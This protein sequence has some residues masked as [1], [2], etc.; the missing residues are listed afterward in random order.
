MSGRFTTA[1]Q[2]LIDN[3]LCGEF[4]LLLQCQRSA[5]R[6][7]ETGCHDGPEQMLHEEAAYIAAAP[8]FARLKDHLATHGRD[9]QMALSGLS[10]RPSACVAVRSLTDVQTA[11]PTVVTNRKPLPCNVFEGGNLNLDQNREL[12]NSPIQQCTWCLFCHC[13]RDWPGCR[14]HC[15]VP[16]SFA[17][18]SRYSHRWGCSWQGRYLQLSNL[19]Q[20]PALSISISRWDRRHLFGSCSSFDLVKFERRR[21]GSDHLSR[22]EPNELPI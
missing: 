21:P 8:Q 11:S 9:I 2:T 7:Q 16:G 5:R 4:R 22:T 20:E 14:N 3:S 17:G 13:R 6:G 10:M 15:R 18:N 1:V 12:D 19:R